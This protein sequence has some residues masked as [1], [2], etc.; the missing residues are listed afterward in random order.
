MIQVSEALA[1]MMK[2]QY[3]LA[4]LKCDTLPDG[5][6]AHKLESYLTDDEFK[7]SSLIPN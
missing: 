6:D 7:V 3:T 5:V 1:S 2:N 4:E